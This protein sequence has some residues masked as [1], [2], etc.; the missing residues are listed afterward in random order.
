[1]NRTDISVVVPLLNEEK[2][3]PGFLARLEPLR[4][5][6]WI[7]VDGGSADRS[8]ALLSDWI[9][10]PPREGR[11]LLRSERGRGRQMNAGAKQAAGEALLFL[12]VDSTLPP[13]GIEAIRRAL[14][15]PEVAGGAFRLKIDSP[16]PFLKLVGALA[17]LRARLLKLPYGD[18]GIFVRRALFERLG[19]FATEPLMEDVDLVR[20]IRQTGKVVLLKEAI[21]TSP[22]R[23]TREG[24]YYGS[25][26]NLV[27]IGLF[28]LG[29][30]PRTLARWYRPEG[31]Q[32]EPS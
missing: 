30:S 25:L 4:D 3:L 7:F 8:G 31:G 29:V 11:R 26:R 14:A 16:H 1:M 9:G 6:E 5:V 12:H 2:A 19:G 20:R 17:N 28:L 32:R 18:Q 24:I 23:W 21:T 27:L 22:R 15:R 13:G 10:T